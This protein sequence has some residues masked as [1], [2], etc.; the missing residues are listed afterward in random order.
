MNAATEELTRA[1]VSLLKALTF[2]A[3]SVT[4]NCGTSS[5]APLATAEQRL[6]RD[7]VYV[8]QQVI[9]TFSIRTTHDVFQFAPPP[10]PAAQLWSDTIEV[11]QIRNALIDGRLTRSID[12]RRAL[13]PLNTGELVLP[14]VSLEIGIKV[15]SAR[16]MQ[17]PPGFDDA[18]VGSMFDDFFAEYERRDVMVTA[19]A[20]ALKI[21]ALPAQPAGIAKSGSVLVGATNI[22]ARLDPPEIALGES[23][24]LSVTVVSLGNLNPIK[25]LPVQLPQSFKV[26]PGN[27]R[28]ERNENNGALISRKSFTLSLVPTH[29]G[30]F[31]IPPITLWFFDPEQNVYRTAQTQ[32]M[33]LS[34]RG[35]TAI[36]QPVAD[37]ELSPPSATPSLP[38]TPAPYAHL[39]EQRLWWH[40]LPLNTAL[41]VLLFGFIAVICAFGLA[42]Y[43]STYHK[44]RTL[45]RKIY[46]TSTW[47]ELAQAVSE[48]LLRK[49]TV[50]TVPS[51]SVEWRI[52]LRSLSLNETES[53]VLLL[54]F[55]Q[56]E[57]AHRS[58]P[59]SLEQKEETYQ[60]LLRILYSA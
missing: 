21:M 59:I 55:L 40:I 9:H 6:S 13:Y 28:D 41:F 23:S 44:R 14:E 47:Q 4:I 20:R 56:V 58:T 15:K 51:S 10:V 39:P 7:T 2:I 12:T 38:P 48:L 22:S 18:F 19:P 42:A 32:A 30:E 36:Q 5:A 37:S 11:N 54:P 3:L 57:S 34:V 16:R 29:G 1:F 52:A 26:Y 27:I 35:S 50:S 25:D 8:G 17:L 31:S 33:T 46:N 53:I 43:Y 60:T 49:I 45:R 24:N